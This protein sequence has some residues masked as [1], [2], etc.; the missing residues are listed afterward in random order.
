MVSHATLILIVVLIVAVSA[1]PPP[2]PKEKEGDFHEA[3]SK[4]VKGKMVNGKQVAG[5]EATQKFLKGDD[6]EFKAY[7]KCMKKELEIYKW[8]TENE[9]KGKYD[10]DKYTDKFADCLSNTCATGSMKPKKD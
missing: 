5:K 3:S 10:P 1:D 8:C 4:C 2:K 9:C 6:D 7:S